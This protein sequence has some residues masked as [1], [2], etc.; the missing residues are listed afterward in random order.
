LLGLIPFA[1]YIEPKV[2]IDAK[3]GVSGAGKKLSDNTAYVNINEN[4]FAYA[5]LTHRHFPEIDE[6]VS[7]ITNTNLDISFVPHLLPVSRGMLIST[8]ATI[9]DEYLDIN[10]L[11]ILKEFYKDNKFVRIYDTPVNI[12]NSSGTNYCDIFASS[13]NNTLFISSAIDNLLRGAS[14]QAVVN[15]NIMCGFAED[16]GIPM[17]AYVP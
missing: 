16:M 1:K 3:S 10:P 17:I 4:I 5:P 9:K 2:F 8:Y 15:A 11:E 6:K 7:K 14:S 13:S 12:K